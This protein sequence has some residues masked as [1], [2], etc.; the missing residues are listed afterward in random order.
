MAL[1]PTSA[2]ILIEVGTGVHAGVIGV[3]VV[4]DVGRS[5]YAFRGLTERGCLRMRGLRDIGWWIQGKGVNKSRQEEEKKHT[6][7]VSPED[8]TRLREEIGSG[9]QHF[10]TRLLCI[11]SMETSAN[12]TEWAPCRGCCAILDLLEVGWVRLVSLD[13][14]H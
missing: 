14:T 5:M 6:P 7:A 10:G 11:Y 3:D 12:L 1:V 2:D 13:Q 9:R 8:S 4:E